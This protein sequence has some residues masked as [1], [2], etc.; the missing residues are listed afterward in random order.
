MAAPA[1]AERK[2]I[3]IP[4]EGMTCAACQANVQRALGRA[5]G[6]ERAAVNLM[7]HDAMVVYDPVLASPQSLVDAVNATGYQ[8]H[9]PAAESQP[10]AEDEAREHAHARETAD[11]TRKAVVSLILGAAAMIASMPLMG[12]GAH[13]VTSA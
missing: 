1:V 12:G 3:T 10:I 11:L 8:S 7:T 2:T 9:L 13:H 5:P 4:V 6:V